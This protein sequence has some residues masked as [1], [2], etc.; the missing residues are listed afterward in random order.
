MQRTVR[1]RHIKT[2]NGR[3]YNWK[4]KFSGVTRKFSVIIGRYP[5]DRTVRVV[6]GDGDEQHG[7]DDADEAEYR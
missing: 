1:S 7:G 3:V 6:V 2:G 4:W 5:Q